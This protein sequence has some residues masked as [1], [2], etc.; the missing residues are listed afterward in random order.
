MNDAFLAAASPPTSAR[1]RFEHLDDG[2][3]LVRWDEFLAITVDD[4]AALIRAGKD[5]ASGRCALMLVELNGMVTL[6]RQAFALLAA[7]LDAQ[8]V[9][10]TGSSAVEKVLVTHFRA[11]HRPPYP[12]E[13]FDSRAEAHT[14]LHGPPTDGLLLAR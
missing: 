10:F 12:V 2:T 5:S 8:A 1:F 9:A 13:Y 6:S 11:V 14:W 4:V 7:S 3:L